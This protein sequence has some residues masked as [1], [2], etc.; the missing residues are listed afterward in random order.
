MVGGFLPCQELM[1]T[2]NKIINIA[3]ALLSVCAFWFV[4]SK[5]FLNWSMITT[6]PRQQVPFWTVV[7]SAACV[8]ASASFSL[9]FAWSLLLRFLGQTE[10]D[11]RL[12]HAIYAR[13]QIAKYAPGNIF[14]FAGRH[15]WG[16][17]AGISHSVLVGATVLEALGLVSAACAVSLI[18][19]VSGSQIFGN[20]RWYLLGLLTALFLPFITVTAVKYIRPLQLPN[21]STRPLTEILRPLFRAYSLYILFFAISGGILLWLV[22]LVGGTP[23]IKMSG[24]VFSA[25]AASWIGGYVTPGSPAGLGVRESLVIIILNGIMA[26]PMALLVAL[27]LR[28]ITITGDLL[29]FTTSFITIRQLKNKISPTG[30]LETK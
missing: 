19:F 9:S 24:I 20:A 29:Y 13:T 18:G 4:G 30:H 5:V 17:K 16:K 27:A 1:R 15:V 3:G 10:V 14:H 23:D 2:R 26:E 11:F 6:W 21:V 8:Y 28:C 25:Y 12:W 7:F 22:G